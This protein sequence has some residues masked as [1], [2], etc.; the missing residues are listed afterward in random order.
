MQIK[1]FSNNLLNNLIGAGHFVRAERTY[2]AEGN[3]GAYVVFVMTF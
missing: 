3:S 1:Q 2:Y